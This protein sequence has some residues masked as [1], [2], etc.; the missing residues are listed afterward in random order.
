[1]PAAAGK[2]GRAG[3]KGRAHL[4]AIR[5]VFYASA[6]GADIIASHKAWREGRDN[7]TEVSITF[8]GQVEE[9][10]RE[11]GAKALLISDRADGAVLE[12]GD[13]RL[14]HRGKHPRSG[15]PY[16]WE[17][18]R[19]CLMLSRAARSFR[20]D[21][22]LVD[23]GV[24]QFFMLSLFPLFGIPVVPILH[25][26]LWARGFR[27]QSRGQKLIQ[28]LDA[29]FWRHGA[30]ATIAVSPEAQRQVEEL[31]G[32]RHPPIRQIRAQFR[33]PFFANIPP[34]NPDKNPFE[35]M[36]IGRVVEAKGVLDLPKMAR[37]I[38]DH[39]PGLVRWTICGRGDTLDR[40]R[41]LVAE[42]DLETVVEVPGWVSLETLQG[43][44]AKSHCWIVPT[45]SGFA[46]GLAMTAAESIMA[47]RPIVAN[48]IVPALEV[49]AP[50]AVGARS[51][52]WQSHAEAVRSL[53]ED[54]QLYRRL[55]AACAP[56]AEQFFDRDRGL[57]AV[58]VRTFA[59]SPEQRLLHDA[60]AS[61]ETCADT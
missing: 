3:E 48:P 54:R 2:A 31:S 59:E 7:P 22:A 32:P 43:L 20:A 52:D 39:E 8:S 5:R 57:T 60:G 46:E 44:Y 19:Y 15:I 18:L 25:N 12:D 4:S 41:A 16:F 56:L 53:A 49:L 47:G 30:R 23:S 11:I 26:C 24:T 14:E 21:L 55:Q 6:G 51:N 34:P 37:F 38:E 10:C 58:L 35:V 40:V 33:R 61:V 17:E 45:R 42:L 50:A 28:W 29:R 9:F 13:F 27:P 1:M 36:F